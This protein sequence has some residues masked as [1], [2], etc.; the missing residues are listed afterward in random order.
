VGAHSPT[1]GG[2]KILNKKWGE[3][4]GVRGT[5]LKGGGKKRVKSCDHGWGREKKKQDR[6]AFQGEN[7][8]RAKYEDNDQTGFYRTGRGGERRSDQQPNKQDQAGANIWE[9]TIL[10]VRIKLKPNRW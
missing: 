4:N 8:Q 7:R 9:E 3:P 6:V 10:G 1:K 2:G 5:T